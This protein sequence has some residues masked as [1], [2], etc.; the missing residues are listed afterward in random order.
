MFVLIL[1]L[2][3]KVIDV[4]VNKVVCF[5]TD[6]SDLFK[7]Y[8]VLSDRSDLLKYYHYNCL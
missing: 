8:F 6:I 4:K 1:L 2:L 7:T 3:Q 5:C